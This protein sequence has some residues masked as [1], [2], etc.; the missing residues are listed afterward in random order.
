[1][2]QID[3]LKEFT[4]YKSQLKKASDKLELLR[5][6]VDGLTYHLPFERAAIFSYDSNTRTKQGM[7]ST[8]YNQKVIL[9]IKEDVRECRAFFQAA[10]E[11][12]TIWSMD[13]TSKK[14]LPVKYIQLFSLQSV[15]VQP[16]LAFNT[17]CGFLIM[18]K[19]SSFFKPEP[20]FLILLQ[21]IG[22]DLGNILLKQKVLPCFPG[23]LNATPVLSPREIQVLQGLAYGYSIQ[24]IA[25][26]L[27]ISYFTVRDYCSSMMKK[28]KALDRTHAVAIGIRN[29]LIS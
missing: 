6:S 11:K 8:G 2:Q 18:D 26:C 12:R 10:L 9:E 29:G 15:V 22:Q 5:A 7:V 28:L 23:K 13:V 4:L 21:A 16:L 25:D 24:E 14:H 3:W 20:D 1:M 19:G 27:R 17:V